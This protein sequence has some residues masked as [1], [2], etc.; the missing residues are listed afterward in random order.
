MQSSI[1][2]VLTIITHQILIKALEVATFFR[3]FIG[4]ETVSEGYVDIIIIIVINHEISVCYYRL[5]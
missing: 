2:R 5:S 1:L 4:K 3:Y